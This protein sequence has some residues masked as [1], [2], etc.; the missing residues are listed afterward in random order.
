ME[1]KIT[2]VNSHDNQ[3]EI[4]EQP[5]ISKPSLKLYVF[6]LIISSKVTMNTDNGIITR[7]I[8]PKVVVE[9]APINVRSGT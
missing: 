2:P 4:L 9:S 8:D 7:Y 6:S 3:N 1:V 5:I